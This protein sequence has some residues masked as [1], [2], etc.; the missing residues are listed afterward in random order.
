[1]GQIT[2]FF[3][4]VNYKNKKEMKRNLQ[5]QRIFK[6]SYLWLDTWMKELQ[7][8]QISVNSK[9]QDNGLGRVA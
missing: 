7:K 2:Q 9:N 5:I 4:Q 8:M 1:M 3:K 6:L